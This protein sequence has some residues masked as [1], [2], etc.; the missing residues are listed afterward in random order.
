[1]TGEDSRPVSAKGAALIAARSLLL[2]AGRHLSAAQLEGGR[3]LLSYLELGRWV[4]GLPGD[5]PSTVAGVNELFA[6]ACSRLSGRR[7]LYLEFGVYSGR[8]MRWWASHL[9]A[10]EAK[11]VGFDSFQG[12]PQDWRAGIDRGHFATGAPPV[13]DDPR[14][15]FV[16]GWFD[17]TLPG[18]Q[19]PEHDQLLVNVDCDLYSSAAT[20]LR[21]LEPHL[22]PA[23]LLYFDELPDRDH[24]MR[25]LREFLERSGRSL[26]PVGY[27]RGGVHWLFQVR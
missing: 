9:H 19:M 15:S 2:R 3:L 17:E 23:D 10:P 7:P 14:V 18:Y 1:M 27:A 11:L 5:P 21:W 25:A 24:E 26:L 20:V 4:A 16:V 12:L 22:R 8:S 13:I 6:L